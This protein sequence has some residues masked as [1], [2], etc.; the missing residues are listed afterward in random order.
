M[1]KPLNEIL[2]VR[3][4]MFVLHA[5][6]TDTC[7][8]LPIQIIMRKPCAACHVLNGS[9]AMPQKC[10]AFGTAAFFKKYCAHLLLVKIEFSA[11]AFHIRLS[12]KG[13]E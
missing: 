1:M 5:I 2:T 10:K 6:Q 12:A 3:A 11:F 9:N 8:Q 13:E 7:V 4:L